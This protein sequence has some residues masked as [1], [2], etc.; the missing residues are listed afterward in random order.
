[1]AKRS[2]V[3]SDEK[4]KGSA[5]NKPSLFNDMLIDALKSDV[6][7]S[8]FILGRDD[9]PS[10]VKEWISTGN[11]VLDMCISNNPDSGGGVPVGRLTE[12]HGDSSTGKSLLGYTILKNCAEKG[13]V[14]VLLDT[15]NSANEEFMNML[16]LNPEENL[17]YS[18]P[19]TVEDVFKSIE[20]I[21]R[22]T[23]KSDKGR[24]VTIVWDSVAATSTKKEMEEDV[25]QANVALMARTIGQG[26]RKI[27]RLLGHERIAL[28]F[29]NQLR[30]KIG[31]VFGDPYTTPGGNAIPFF[32][33]VRIRLYTA[34]KITIA[35]DVIGITT[36]AKVIKTRFGPPF[37]EAML[38]VY[39][40][41]GLV[42]EESWEEYLKTKKFITSI[43]G[44]R[45]FKLKLDGSEE[46]HEYKSKEF[47]EF[48]RSNPELRKK[49]EQM[50]RNDL[51]VEQDPSKR[52][53][54][55]SIE[56]LTEDEVDN[57]SSI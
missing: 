35:K 30:S 24:L 16:G 32:A 28:I 19:D 56:E 17:V 29:L 10:D 39:F 6:G 31:V 38:K 48:I 46:A 43:S 34:G 47:V 41:R 8:S 11:T 2:V 33:D 42:Q 4:A 25:G 23:R 22:T 53:E 14:S 9:S 15:E 21:I 55:E 12:I 13:G 18:V 44:T 7:G 49:I 57:I 3:I 51:Y 52:E 50:I 1:M 5:D 45:N 54:E 37:R 40:D 27:K 20:T 26:M 36:K